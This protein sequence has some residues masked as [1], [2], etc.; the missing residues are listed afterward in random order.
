MN[1]FPGSFFFWSNKPTPGLSA[2]FTSENNNVLTGPNIGY[3]KFSILSSVLNFLFQLKDNIRKN[4]DQIGFRQVPSFLEMVKLGGLKR[5]GRGVLTLHPQR[6]SWQQGPVFLSPY[7]H[8]YLPTVIM[9]GEEGVESG[10]LKI[11]FKNTRHV[12]FR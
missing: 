9:R 6:K 5:T 10:S 8:D 2:K 7:L 3:P 11:I 1:F 4:L 12:V